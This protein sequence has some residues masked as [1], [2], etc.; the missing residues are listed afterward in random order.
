MIKLINDYVVRV[1]TMSYTLMVDTHKKDK[2]GNDLYKTVGYYS[3]LSS[4]IK[5]CIKDINR[6]KL[7]VDTITLEE[8]VKVIMESNES[9]TDL[10][11]KCLGGV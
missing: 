3:T 11:N 1:D 4:A 6:S 7:A 9:V 10:L 8:A 5:G 2:K